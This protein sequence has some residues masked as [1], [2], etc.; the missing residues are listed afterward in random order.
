MCVNGECECWGV[1][2]VLKH[3]MSVKAQ[4]EIEA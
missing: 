3:N 1:M 2:W 4:Y